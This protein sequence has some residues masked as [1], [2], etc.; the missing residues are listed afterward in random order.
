[1]I[2]SNFFSRL[3][4][5]PL[6]H[7]MVL[8]AALFILY[9][10]V[11]DDRGERYD[12]IVVDEVEVLRLT[13]QFQR[14]WMRPPSRQ[15]LEGLAEDF[16]KEEILYRE[17]LALGLDQDDLV[18]RR[19]LS[20]KMEFLNTDLVAQ[21]TPTEEQLQTY[22]NS[23]PDKFMRPAHISFQ[24]IYLGGGE[25]TDNVQRKAAALLERL[26]AEP[27]TVW[28]ELGD[29][30]LL[31]P[32]LTDSSDRY[33]ATIFGNALVESI[34][35]A[36]LDRWSGPHASAYGQHLVRVTGRT[37]ASLPALTEVR[38]QV[39]REWGNERRVQSNEQFYLKLRERYA[40]EIHLPD[41]AAGDKLAA[42]Q[43]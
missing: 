15:E 14:T 35:G 2:S 4:R 18:I 38:A 43:Q 25:G 5:E 39:E 16:V 36:P 6:V 19:R 1:M 31:P 34:A 23:H 26:V 17:A 9:Y 32:A 33:I 12:R 24:Q 41:A 21:Q 40:V 20:Q 29:P 42:R 37:P 30:T 28:Q 11:G 3:I 8:G 22:L 13:G 7:F 10:H 27:E